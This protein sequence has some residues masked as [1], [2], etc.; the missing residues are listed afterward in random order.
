MGGPPSITLFFLSHRP[1]L[2]LQFA[3]CL[4]ERH[5]HY[6]FSSPGPQLTS[7]NSRLLHLFTL[8]FSGPTIHTCS[9]S[10]VS[11]PTLLKLCEFSVPSQYSSHLLC[12]HT[13][14]R[15]GFD[16]GS[17]SFLVLRQGLARFRFHR[18]PLC[19]QVNPLDSQRSPRLCLP[20]K[21][22]DEKFE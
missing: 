16:G 18:A 7:T 22:W 8:S 15:C 10:L 13:L 1:A 19:N 6:S 3:S 17:S 21:F 11:C 5:P 14:R 9:H 2:L 20:P 4:I 12:S